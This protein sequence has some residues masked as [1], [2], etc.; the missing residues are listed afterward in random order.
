MTLDFKGFVDGE[1]FEGGEGKDYPLE[2]GSNRFIPGFEDQ[3]IG[4]KIGEARD[5][6]VTFPEEYHSKDL[7]GKPAKFECTIHS[8]KERQLPER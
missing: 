5:V 6:N 2:I 8:I 3:L 7:A 4:A 1:A